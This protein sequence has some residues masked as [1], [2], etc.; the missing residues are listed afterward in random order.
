MKTMFKSF[1]M[2]AVAAC[3]GMSI[4]S[5]TADKDLYN[6]DVVEQNVKADFESNFISKFGDVASNQNWMGEV[7]FYEGSYDFEYAEL[8][9]KIRD[10]RLNQIAGGS[11]LFT[12]GGSV[13]DPLV[14]TLATEED[15]KADGEDQYR[16]MTQETL[17]DIRKILPQYVHGNSG[18]NA[19]NKDKILSNFEFYARETTSFYIYPM[20]WLCGSQYVGLYW[21]D[22]NGGVHNMPLKDNIDLTDAK[23]QPFFN[24]VNAQ[25]EG[26]NDQVNWSP[27]GYKKGDN[28]SEYNVDKNW[29]FFSYIIPENYD[30]PKAPDYY[31]SRGYRVTIP[32]NTTFGLYLYNTSNTEARVISKDEKGNVKYTNEKL[33]NSGTGKRGVWSSTPALND[34]LADMLGVGHNPEISPLPGMGTFRYGDTTYF[35]VECGANATYNDFFFEISPKP[36][37]I[38]YD[39]ESFRFMCEDLGT[40]DDFDYN[41]LVFDVTHM[42]G[43]EKATLTVQAAGGT[44]PMSLSYDG[45][46]L[47]PNV[48]D[49]FDVST[50]T[51]VNTGMGATKD[52]YS[53]EFSV[54][55]NFFFTTHA[56]KFSVGV[57]Y[58]DGSAENTITIP[59]QPGRVPQAFIT[60]T[61]LPWS[62]ERVNIDKTYPS[63]K[64]WVN[65][66]LK[67][68]WYETDFNLPEPVK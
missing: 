29:E 44:L 42:V 30:N 36:L 39:D 67:H 63:F 61:K 1:S 27:L 54:P 38:D 26:S 20:Y 16:Y 34:A 14:V 65:E 15:S 49:G 3:A 37:I 12:R 17:Q 40:T 6:P 18:P 31:R 22:D 53:V 33:S 21:V 32:A 19:N 55:K 35:T 57:Q 13:A 58:K 56:Q 43:T 52:A 60:N 47:I 59:L 5:C 2:L 7:A 11:S 10:M 4:A 9:A 48:K 28:R 25:V 62:R 8:V 68:C 24:R 64:P 46:V 66:N 23:S 41:D 50:S 45:Q 51:M